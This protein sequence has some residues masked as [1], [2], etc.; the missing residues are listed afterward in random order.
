[1]FIDLKCYE[2]DLSS[3]DTSNVNNCLVMFNNIERNCIIKISNKFTKCREQI[4]YDVKVINVD[5]N[6]C[7][8]YDN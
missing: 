3:F 7:K 5:E 1:M 8:N 2:L 6:N 4:P